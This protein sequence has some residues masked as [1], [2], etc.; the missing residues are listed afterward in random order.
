MRVNKIKQMW[1]EKKTATM[2]WLSVGHS[3]TAEVMAR[4]GGFDSLCVDL[5]HGCS[6]EA[7]MISM[8]Q[9]TQAAVKAQVEKSG[10]ATQQAFLISLGAA[11]IALIL[12]VQVSYWI[13]RS[14][15]ERLLELME[16]GGRVSSYESLALE[17]I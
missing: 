6:D 10:E 12:S 16:S 11:A 2:G 5:Q 15:S 4:Q 3:F 1:R 14:I 17:T 7:T 8:F 13:V 9:A